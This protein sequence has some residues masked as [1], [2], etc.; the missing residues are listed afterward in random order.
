[1]NFP[2]F[3][4]LSSETHS[5]ISSVM[6]NMIC[7]S[8]SPS[9]G[10]VI[11]LL[12]PFDEDEHQLISTKRRASPK[13][14][15]MAEIS[16]RLVRR[17]LLYNR[18]HAISI[19]MCSLGLFG[20]LLMIINNEIIFSNLFP[21]SIYIC[22]F[23]KLFITIT[24]LIL[25]GF[26]FYYRRL[27]LDLYAINNSFKH[28][29]IGLNTSKIFLTFIEVFICLIHPV[30][31]PIP[32]LSKIQYENSTIYNSTSPDYI[33]LDVAL[34]LPSY[35]DVTPT[36]YC[37]RSVAAITA[38]IGV[39]STALL[40]SVLARKLELSR[41]EKYV[42]NFVLNMKLVKDRKHQA[43]NVIKFVLKLWILRRKNQ[44]SSNEFLKAQRGL[45]RSM[46]FNQ[47]IKQEQ[48]KL[49]DNCVGMP[50]LIIMQRD[51]NDKTYENTST[52]I[53]MKGKIEKIEEKLC[54]IDQTM[55]DIQNS[56]RILSNQ[57]AK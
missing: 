40:I 53:V 49:V 11:P 45:V 25:I 41:A 6:T 10:S 29:R 20:V 37:G 2:L 26:I 32:F 34:G 38:M 30:P 31:L 28:W 33:T 46:H 36:T 22:W 23:I 15:L 18:L 51:T 54:Q 1:M 56:L 24:T 57:L 9:V 5:A 27:D 43:S 13:T 12:K 4:S 16:R 35:G 48:K 50:E 42:H 3:T 7:M 39:L 55:I 14:I 21:R 52:L 44:A 17:K 19:I 8:N 47:Q